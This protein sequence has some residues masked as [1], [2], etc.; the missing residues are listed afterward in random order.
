MLNVCCDSF[1]EKSY[2][3]KDRQIQVG[4]STLSGTN[5]TDHLRSILDGLLRVERSLLSGESLADHFCVF[6]ESQVLPRRL[7]ARKS[8]AELAQLKTV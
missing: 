6:R 5:T 2:R 7:V 3:V 8:N 4:S 1:L